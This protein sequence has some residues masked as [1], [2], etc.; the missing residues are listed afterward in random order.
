MR[1]SFFT[2]LFGFLAFLFS[3]LLTPYFTEGDQILY[4][5]FYMRMSESPNILIGFYDYHLM[6][7][8]QEPIYFSLV[9]LLSPLIEKDL[10]FSIIN[11]LIGY[12]FAIWAMKNKVHKPL[13]FLV[14]FTNYYVYA[15]FFELERLKVGLFIL[16]LLAVIHGAR[17]RISL[18]LSS[19]AHFQI[20]A[21]LAASFPLKESVSKI[22]KKSLKIRL[23]KIIFLCVFIILLGYFADTIVGKIY[24][25]S[26][27]IT[28]DRVFDFFK[29]LAFTIMTILV[30]PRWARKTVFLSGIAIIAI[31]ILVGANRIAIFAFFIFMY[32]ALQKN[33]GFNPYLLITSIYFAYSGWFFLLNG[34]DTGNGYIPE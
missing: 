17:Y 13:I 4:H 20:G 19:F 6:L 3:Y 33:R 5:N 14:F 16:L 9:Y 12:M 11:G 22:N 25:Y 15:L 31:S 24:Y 28:R 7:G 26:A 21:L 18:I 27:D 23:L 1:I 2:L 8:A 34:I 10:L 32:W 29:P 30:A